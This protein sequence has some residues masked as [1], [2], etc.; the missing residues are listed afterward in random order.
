MALSEQASRIDCREVPIFSRNFFKQNEKIAL[1]DI[2]KDGAE[3]TQVYGLLCSYEKSFSYWRELFRQSNTAIYT[4]WDKFNPDHMIISDAIK[5]IGGISSLYQ[6]SYEVAPSPV[7]SVATDIFFGFSQ[8]SAS[9]EKKSDSL[10]PYYVVTG[11]L[12]DYLF[13]NLRKLACQIRNE[14]SK[15]GAKKIIAYLDNTTL[16]DPRWFIGHDTMQKNYAYLLNA[17]LNNPELGL[18]IKPKKPF[19][20][21]KNLGSVSQILESAIKTGRCYLFDQRNWQGLN[22]DVHGSYPPAVAA[23]ASDIT[24]CDNMSSGTAAVESTLAGV[25]TLL[26]DLEGLH[27]SPFYKLGIGQVIFNQ[28]DDLWEACVEYWHSKEKKSGFGDWGPIINELDPFRDGRAAERMGTYFKWILDG[29]KAGMGR[30][31][32][33]IDA[34]ERYCKIWGN[35]KIIEIK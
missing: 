1:D 25:K 11:Y 10:I 21:Y 8:E 28:W 19:A 4:S 27:E 32:I 35:D 34:A 9:I 20:L 15:K 22:L 17:V 3:A 12:N 5:S 14:L 26:L 16:D 23:L 29:F 13:S 18:V 24:I 31:D 2:R 7:L 6:R 30:D 33:L